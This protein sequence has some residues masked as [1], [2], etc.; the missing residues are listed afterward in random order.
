MKKTLALIIIAITTVAITITAHGA[1]AS[2]AFDKAHSILNQ[3]D[4]YRDKGSYSQAISLYGEA[5]T[6]YRNLSHK[7]PEWQSGVVKFRINYCNDQIENILNKLSERTLDKKKPAPAPAKT[8]SSSD[9]QKVQEAISSASKLLRYGKHMNARTHLLKA[10]N[11]DP[12]NRTV[13]LLLGISQ[14][15]AGKYK[16]AIFILDELVTEDKTN[17]KAHI[18]LGAAYLALGDNNKAK[19]S[20]IKALKLN[21]NSKEANFNMAQILIDSDPPNKETAAKYYRKALQLGAIR[22]A[23]LELSLK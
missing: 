15:Q 21:P 22:N 13:R 16:D 2:A 23:T 7:Y 11:I 19:R 12:D 14:C 8:Q 17:A 18:V 5:Q 10:I 3:A 9:S 4:M 6:M 1:T 20:T